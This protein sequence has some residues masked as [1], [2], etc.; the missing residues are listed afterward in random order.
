M[1]KTDSAA[2]ANSMILTG[3]GRVDYC[4]SCRI[5]KSTGDSVAQI[6]AQLF[7][8]PKWV[9]GLM[10]V[11]NW[12]VKPFGLKT[13]MESE[14][15]SALFPV[16]GQNENEILMEVVDRHLN[17]RVSIW[18]DREKSCIYLTTL[19]HYNN[20]WGKI[21]FLPVKPF[22]KIIVRSIMRRLLKS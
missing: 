13:G 11:R 15:T 2:L 5:T 7:N 14:K 10:T 16:I 3:F 1:F 9:N 19:V 22:H 20:G 18:V 21:Y 8:L 6:A 17:V 12:T 4:D